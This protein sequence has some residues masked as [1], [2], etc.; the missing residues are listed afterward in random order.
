[1]LTLAS[2]AK[3]PQAELDSASQAV[4]GA[5][6]A[7]ASEY[8][9]DSLRAAEDALA[10]MNDEVKLQGERMGIMRS[11]DKAKQLAAEAKAA[12]DKAAADAKAGLERARNEAS[13]AIEEAKTMLANAQAAVDQAP[14]GKGTTADIAAMKATLAG[15]QE[16][17]G[18]TEAAFASGR[19]G[20]AKAQAQ[21]AMQSAD[22]IRVEVESAIAAR[23]QRGRGQS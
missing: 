22:Q 9:A 3:P 7:Q 14:T 8:A 11:Y 12:G 1:M 15:V 21:A 4:S 16:S 6:S 17:I 20:E 2:C 19:F 23:G 5:K 18:A 13:Q 10:R